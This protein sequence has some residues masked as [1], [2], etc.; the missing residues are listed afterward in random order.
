MATLQ[1]SPFRDF[2][3]AVEPD[4]EYER[5]T[6][7]LG[8]I[9][10]DD[11]DCEAYGV[12]THQKDQYDGRIRKD[13][14]ITFW[15][16]LC[17]EQ[18]KQAADSA[19][20]T[21]ERA[22]AHLSANNVVAACEALVQGKDYRLA[23]LVAQIGGDQAMH[24]QISAQVQAWNNLNVLSE[25]SEPIRALYSLLAGEAYMCNGT[26]RNHIEDKVRVFPISERFDLDWKRAFGLRLYYAISNDDPIEAAIAKFARELEDGE[27]KKPSGDILYALLQVYAASKGVLPAPSLAH[28]LVPQTAAPTPLTARLSFQLYHILT[29]RFPLSVNLQAADTL[30]T[31]FAIQLNA[32]NEWL[33]AMFA[34]LHIS[35]PAQ[36]QEGIQALLAYRA[37]DIKADPP[38]DETWTTLSEELKIPETWI[39]EAKALYA[40]AVD[41]DRMREA[42]YLVRAGQWNQ[43]HGVLKSVVGPDC[44][45]AEEWGQLQGLL[46]SFKPG[47]EKIRDWGLGGQVYED[48]LHLAFKEPEG[49]EKAAVLGRLLESLPTMMHDLEEE[50]KKKRKEKTSNDE[51]DRKDGD[52]KMRFREMVALQEISGVVGKEVLAME[53]EVFLLPLSSSLA[54]IRTS[55]SN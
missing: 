28:I 8:S 53:E 55:I 4:S 26:P 7:T 16:E 10:F 33:W 49:A 51:V 39:W 3:I 9:L 14:F 30:A 24:E 27:P 11:Q 5:A 46:V 18:A 17:G 41:G 6:W 42:N 36:R 50:K 19:P 13:R 47:K 54:A 32:A 38:M 1:Q 52:E 45:I 25:M 43:A 20:D 34:L 35:N 21:E 22:I 37:R 12:P 40:R 44:V 23:T 48:Y 29:I 2:A 15:Q 31:T